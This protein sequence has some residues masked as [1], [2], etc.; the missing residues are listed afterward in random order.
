MKTILVIRMMTEK[1]QKLNWAGHPF[2]SSISKGE[3]PPWHFN[4]VTVT[5]S[6]FVEK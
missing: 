3:R 5:M 2:S 1:S 6:Y 4:I